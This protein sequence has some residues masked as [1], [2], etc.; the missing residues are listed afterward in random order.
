M[1]ELESLC[2][3]IRNRRANQKYKNIFFLVKVFYDNMVPQIPH[4]F[5]GHNV[6]VKEVK[7]GGLNFQETQ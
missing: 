6:D 3:C 4:K 1:H 2:L 7:E 5:P